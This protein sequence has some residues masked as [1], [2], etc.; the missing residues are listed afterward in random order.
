[1]GECLLSAS[2]RHASPLTASPGLLPRGAAELVEHFSAAC[3]RRLVAELDAAREELA[4]LPVRRRVARA[5]RTR[6]E[7]NGVHASS[8]AQALSLQA[9]PRNAMHALRQ[10]AG[11]VDEVWSR[12][13]D[14]ST[15]ALNWYVKRGALLGVYSTTEL[16]MVTD[17]TPAFGAT[18]AHLDA[19]LE[20]SW[21]AGKKG[22][23]ALE[24]ARTL[25]RRH[26]V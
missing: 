8:W 22:S 2:L 24:L 15:D 6:L 20:Q 4:G 16:Y 19:L 17:L 12:A 13:G 21:E 25:S 10:R 9:H 7:M 14:T 3:D 23:E 18:W 11:V 1:V 26:A 5:L